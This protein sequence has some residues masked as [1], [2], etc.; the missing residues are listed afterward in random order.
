MI[1]VH[2]DLPDN[3][4]DAECDRNNETCVE[5]TNDEVKV[6]YCI[7]AGESMTIIMLCDRI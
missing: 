6:A 5:L 2:A 3:C 4:E 7:P 1:S